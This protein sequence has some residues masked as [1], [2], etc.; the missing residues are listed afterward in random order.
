MWNEKHTKAGGLG[1]EHTL[2]VA[3]YCSHVS[4]SDIT[5]YGYHLGQNTVLKNIRTGVP[6]TEYVLGVSKFSG[7]YTGSYCAAA[8]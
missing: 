5:L 6:F 8:V 2:K 4:R 3:Y 1:I 7:P